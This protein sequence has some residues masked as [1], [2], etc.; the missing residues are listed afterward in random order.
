MKKIAGILIINLIVLFLVF[1]ILEYALYRNYHSYHPE[2]PYKIQKFYYDNIFK[3]YRLRPFEGV[4]YNKR[5][6]L[7][8]GCSYAYGQGLTDEQTMGHKLSEYTKRPVY[9]YSLPGKG[10][11]NTIYILQK[12]M[13]DESINNPEYVI[14]VFMSD[15]IRRLYST[16][17]LHD[18]TGYPVYKV[19]RDGTV[20]LKTNY[21]PV[22]RQFYTFYFFNN[23]YQIYFN[24]KFKKKHSR[25]IN[26]YFKEIHKQIQRKY[27]NAKFVILMYEDNGNNFGLNLQP[28]IDDGIEIIHTNELTDV[29]LL[30]DEYHIAPNDFHP[31]EKAWDI[32]V[33]ALSQRLGL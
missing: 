17:C 10:L 31:N 2:I 21:Y 25:I 26:A 24:M 29:R 27:P 12:D 20:V 32:L 6:I 9:N 13:L 16:V 23:I 11:Q 7:L 33:P 4:E 22:Y 8:L 3:A 18:Y 14:Y 19:Q 5:P 1:M 28:L 30:D 15:Q